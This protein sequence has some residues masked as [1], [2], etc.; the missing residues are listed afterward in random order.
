MESADDVDAVA[1]A[2]PELDVL[3]NNAGLSRPGGQ[4]EWMPDVFEQVVTADLLGAFR[5][6]TACKPALCRSAKAG[7]ASVVNIV[8]LAAFGGVEAVVAYGAA[9]AG[10]NQ[11]TKGLAVPWAREGVRV[12]A[13]APGLIATDFAAGMTSNP[14]AAAAFLE[15]IPQRR[16]GR[17]EDV[18][19]A[20]LFL[21]SANAAFIT[22]TTLVVDGGQT[23]VV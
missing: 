17:P 23:A 12:N 4:S 7:G 21:S 5:L 1:D 8:S 6:S 18:A 2:C 3:I 15:K 11:L 9:K 19:P 14:T 13:I 22:G 20:A 10:L 16:F